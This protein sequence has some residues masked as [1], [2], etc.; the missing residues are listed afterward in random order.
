MEHTSENARKYNPIIIR[1]WIKYGI[2]KPAGY[3]QR[4]L[5][6]NEQTV[7]E[8]SRGK[9]TRRL[10]GS[11]RSKIRQQL[12]ELHLPHNAQEISLEVAN[13]VYS[14][15]FKFKNCGLAAKFPRELLKPLAL[16][17]AEFRETALKLNVDV[18]TGLCQEEAE[19]AD[20]QSEKDIVDTATYKLSQCCPNTIRNALVYDLGYLQ[21]DVTKSEP[22]PY[23]NKEM[24][25]VFITKLLSSIKKHKIPPDLVLNMDE[26][27]IEF[28]FTGSKTFERP[29]VKDVKLVGSNDK[30]AITYTPVITSDGSIIAS[31]LILPGKVTGQ[32]ASEPIWQE[33]EH[34][35]S[36]RLSLNHSGGRKQWQNQH[37]FRKLIE[38]INS[39]VESRIEHWHPET[40]AGILVLDCAGSHTSSAAIEILKEFPRIVPIFV[41]PR[42]TSVLQPL[43]RQFFAPFK[44]LMKSCVARCMLRWTKNMQGLDR[45]ES[46]KYLKDCLKKKIF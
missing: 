12:D 33:K 31:Q 1:T 43:D 45:V 35:K 29:S 25:E 28:V 38:A 21:R 6:Q 9:L 41:P 5:D 15:M 18:F 34:M 27:S 44:K 32:E 39:Y 23:K 22:L 37:T 40:T 4:V 17:V 3:I 20:K 36:H 19:I 14:K 11:W 30:R 26:T 8:Y 10:A 46:D 24:G 42:M 7:A 13:T 16:R 2:E